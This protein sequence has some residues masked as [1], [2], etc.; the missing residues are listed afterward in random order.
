MRPLAKSGAK[1][2]TG[3]D[4]ELVKRAQDTRAFDVHAL[5]SWLFVEHAAIINQVLTPTADAVR[6]AQNIVSG[7]EAARERDE[8]RVEIDGSLVEWP[9]YLNA[10]RLLERARVLKSPV[11]RDP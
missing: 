4:R 10:M 7:F 2:E 6:R 1:S 11:R 8:G 3:N 9:S 5:R